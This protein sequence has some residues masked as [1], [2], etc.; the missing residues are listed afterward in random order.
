MWKA[1]S[2]LEGRYEVSDF[3][4]VRN[5]RTGRILAQSKPCPYPSVPLGAGRNGWVHKLVAEAFL[6]ARPEG[7]LV[8]HSNDDPT[9]NKVGNLRYGTRLE[10]SADSNENSLFDFNKRYTDMGRISDLHRAGFGSRRISTWL[11]YKRQ[12]VAGALQRLK[13]EAFG[14]R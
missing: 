14:H 6:G 13:G 8:L 7:H 4:R 12:T 1:I 3:G 2:G 9:D 11:G 5:T 10:N